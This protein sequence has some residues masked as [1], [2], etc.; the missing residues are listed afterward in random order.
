MKSLFPIVLLICLWPSASSVAQHRRTV[1]SLQAIIQDGNTPD[2]TKIK[3]YNDLGVQYAISDPE[4]AKHYIGKALLL[5][6]TNQVPRGLAG[7]QNCMGVVYYYQKQYDSALVWFNKALATNKSVGH[8]WGQASTMHQIG[9]INKFQADYKS[10]IDK[11]QES[12]NIFKKLGDSI[13][14]TKSLE[15][16]GSC[17][18]LMG[19][20]ERALEHYLEAID[21]AQAKRDSMAI[22]R[23]YNHI[24]S[25]LI[26][27]RDY[28]A[29]LGYLERALPI[30]EKSESAY[31]ISSLYYMLGTC[32][33]E[34]K[35]YEA[36]LQ[37]ANESLKLRKSMANKRIIAVAQLLIGKIYRQL[38][39][40][41]K[42]LEY[43]R[44]GISNLQAYQGDYRT[45]V[46]AL[47]EIAKSHFLS[48][49]YD[50]ASY[51]AHRATDLSRKIGYLTGED[52]GN[53]MLAQVAETQGNTE[54]AILHYRNAIG[55]KDSIF[56]MERQKYVDKLRA[57]YETEQKNEQ[58]ELQEV[59]IQLLEQEA[60]S[61]RLQRLLFSIG[62]VL[63]SIIML[64]LYYSSRQ[65]LKSTKL[66]AKHSILEKEKIN[67]EL[68]FKTRELASFA[69]HLEKKNDVL[70]KLKTIIDNPDPSQDDKGNGTVNPKQLLEIINT[71]IKNDEIWDD[72][73]KY[74]EQVHPG[75]YAKMKQNYPDLTSG[76]LRLTILLKMNLTYKEISNILNIT[77]EGVKKARY[78]LRKKMNIQPEESLQDK[79][80]G[81]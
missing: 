45:E 57:I 3:A 46:D 78:R 15:S 53:S 21:I 9:V 36:A 12:G 59:K 37:Y 40:Y 69:M 17:Y 52:E 60:M 43:L 33:N 65:K 50:S 66:I 4:Q 27:Q 41:P 32:H 39:N 23:G 68:A 61:H 75:F 44:Q 55:L 70:D 26:N 28:R 10:A 22:A 80:I 1:D 81:L 8:R 63:V 74:F 49:S 14:W 5:A 62:F 48:Q 18:N 25:M 79:I 35:Q 34:L 54:S 51:H 6:R 29:A 56:N 77:P 72:F 71:E 7:G 47:N 30:V 13:S 24:A 42:S 11:F 20:Y 19:Y 64:L 58:I 76:D 73:K 16:I 67:E 2:T 38:K 31:A